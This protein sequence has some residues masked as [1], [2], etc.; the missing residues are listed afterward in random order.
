MILTTPPQENCSTGIAFPQ[1]GLR[2]E[3]FSRFDSDVLPPVPV[4]IPEGVAEAEATRLYLY[5][6]SGMGFGGFHYSPLIRDGVME[7]PNASH[8]AKPEVSAAATKVARRLRSD[9][10]VETQTWLTAD[11]QPK[12]RV[13]G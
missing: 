7:E 4:Y 10:K 5:C 9:E 2:V 1:R 8:G 3:V 6:E 12:P 11:N 13:R